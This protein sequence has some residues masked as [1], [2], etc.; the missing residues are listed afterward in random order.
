MLKLKLRELTGRKLWQF[1]FY[2]TSINPLGS[3]SH[4]MLSAKNVL[5]SFKY[6]QAPLF[7]T[8]EFEPRY[9]RYRELYL[10]AAQDYVGKWTSM[11]LSQLGK[12][13]V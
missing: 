1:E 9:M 12:F 4:Y 11:T 7:I 2:V 10:I 3:L 8:T 13:I 5:T 6:M